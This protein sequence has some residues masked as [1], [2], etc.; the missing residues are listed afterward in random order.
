MLTS[1]RDLALR[2]AK[3]LKVPLTDVEQWSDYVRLED[4]TNDSKMKLPSSA[5]KGVQAITGYKF[6]RPAILSE[7]LVRDHFQKYRYIS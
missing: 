4:K 7:A 5:A 6:E 2:T 3:I 1:G